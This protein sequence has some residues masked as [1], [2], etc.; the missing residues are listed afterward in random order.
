[1]GKRDLLHREIPAHPEGDDSEISSQSHDFDNEDKTVA[2]LTC[3]GIVGIQ[4]PVRPEVC[5]C[6][7]AC[8][9]ACVRVCVCACVRVSMCKCMRA[10]KQETALQGLLAFLA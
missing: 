3:I 2:G 6:V 5:V 10:N 4:D 7:H 9:R 8:V 1:M